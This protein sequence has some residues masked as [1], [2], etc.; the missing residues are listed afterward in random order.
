MANKDPNAVALGRKGGLKGGPARAEKMTAE[1]RSE[2]A[3]HAAQIRWN[4][5]KGGP[6]PPKGRQK[7]ES[8]Y[9]DDYKRQYIEKKLTVLY[10]AYPSDHAELLSRIADRRE[11][12]R[13]ALIREILDKFLEEEGHM[14][15]KSRGWR[16]DRTTI[17]AIK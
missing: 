1:Q 3:R 4:N 15:P 9:S 5:Q 16:N 12:S 13:T 7:K 2:F 10:T 17:R 11:I 14:K 6:V 8:E